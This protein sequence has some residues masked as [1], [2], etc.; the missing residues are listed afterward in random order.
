M[1]IKVFKKMCMVAGIKLQYM[2]MQFPPTT[3]KPKYILIMKLTNTYIYYKFQ[4][5]L[6]RCFRANFITW[7]SFRRTRLHFGFYY[8]PLFYF[9]SKLCSG[10]IE[11]PKTQKPSFPLQIEIIHLHFFQRLAALSIEKS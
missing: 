6:N 1:R 10:F 11:I 2:R 8:F 9:S 7:A 3:N 4:P 5:C